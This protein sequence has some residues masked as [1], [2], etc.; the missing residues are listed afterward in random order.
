[1]PKFLLECRNLARQHVHVCWLR[2]TPN[3][4]SITLMAQKL[5]HF[6]NNPILSVDKAV[7]VGVG[8]FD[9][10]PIWNLFAKTF[11]LLLHKLPQ[12]A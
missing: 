8:E 10:S 2:R 4:E 12:V 3:R 7:M 6:T 5:P 1:M 11:N 9:D